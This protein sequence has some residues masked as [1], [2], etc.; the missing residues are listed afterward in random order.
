VAEDE[1]LILNNLVKKIHRANLGFEVVATAQD[2]KTALNLVEKYSPDLLITDIRMPIMDGMELL[3]NVSTKYPYIEKLVISGY[4]EF[5]YAQ[6]ALKYQV[7]DYL[8]KPVKFDALIESLN[9]IRICIESK[10]ETSNKNNISIK[11]NYDYTPEQIAHLVE[12]YIKENFTK[13]INFDLV[14]QNFN[15]NSSYLSKIFTKFVGEN[16]SKYV[17][18]LRINK[19]KH[20]LIKNKDQSIKEIGILSGYDDQFYFSR[21]FKSVTGESPASFRN[22]HT[23]KIEE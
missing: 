2:G 13:E 4:G 11:K 12:A 6:Q 23:L 1:E 14:A 10:F 3:K 22:K 19:A 5:N 7:K 15:F 16:P 21:I 8:L 20:L 18:L 9:N 17:I